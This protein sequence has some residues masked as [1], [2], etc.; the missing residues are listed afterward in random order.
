[1]RAAGRRR[2]IYGDVPGDAR[3][4]VDDRSHSRMRGAMGS[5]DRYGWRHFRQ[6][7]IASPDR[8]DE[9]ARRGDRAQCLDKT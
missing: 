4:P 3:R 6:P 7:R 5:P 9:I 2:E 1:M 8:T